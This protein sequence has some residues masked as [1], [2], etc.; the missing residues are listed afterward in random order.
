MQSMSV[1]FAVQNPKN[2]GRNLVMLASAF[3]VLTTGTVTNE[4]AGW[5]QMVCIDSA[6]NIVK[7]RR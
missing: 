5:M 4:R 1:A 7:R 6:R 2:S 3:S